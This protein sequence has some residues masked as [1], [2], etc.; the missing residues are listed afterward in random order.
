LRFIFAE[1]IPMFGLSIWH[2]LIV[3]AVVAVIFGRGRISGL[4]GDIGRGINAF[5]TE[6]GGG[7][8]P[9]RQ[10]MKAISDETKTDSDT[11]EQP[12]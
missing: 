11:T 4:M 2:I 3:L 5:R 8:E 6:I 10:P 7:A 9:P 1:S 12:K